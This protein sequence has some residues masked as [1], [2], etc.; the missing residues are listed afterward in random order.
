MQ[1]H[2]AAI[3]SSLSTDWAELAAIL[4][5]EP[6]LGRIAS[7]T[8]SAPY[9]DWPFHMV[10]VLKIFPLWTTHLINELINYKS[11][12]RTALASPDLLK[13]TLH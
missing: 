6:L 8:D 5:L 1:R 9:G 10:N 3:D 2:L 4:R 12:C 11:V 7:E 13:S